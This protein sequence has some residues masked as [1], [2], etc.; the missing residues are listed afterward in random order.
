M[1]GV[2]FYD[3]EYSCL[4]KTTVTCGCVTIIILV[5]HT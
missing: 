3:K 1:T 2:M 4:S 5:V